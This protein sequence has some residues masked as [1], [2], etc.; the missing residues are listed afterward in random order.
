MMHVVLPLFILVVWLLWIPVC[1][2]SRAARGDLGGT[3]I[4]PGIPVFP[5]AAW[6]LSALLEWLHPN[7]GLL[8]IGGS[9]VL[10]LLVFLVSAYRSLHAIKRNRSNVA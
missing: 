9:H 1:V 3:S 7:L 6:G 10:L 8:V 4:F 2:W 5:L